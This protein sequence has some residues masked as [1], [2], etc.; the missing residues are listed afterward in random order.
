MVSAGVGKK[1]KLGTTSFGA[2]SRK[3]G[4]FKPSPFDGP[5]VLTKGEG[6]IKKSYDFFY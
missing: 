6:S 5:T 4:N 1:V 3:T 2:F